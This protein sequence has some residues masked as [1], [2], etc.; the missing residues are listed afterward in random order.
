MANLPVARNFFVMSSNNPHLVYVILGTPGAGRRAVL[1]DLIQDG[2]A[3]D[4]KAL[5]LL[6]T[7]EEPNENDHRLGTV[8][9]WTW[10]DNLIALAPSAEP[11]GEPRTLASLVPGFTHVLFVTEGRRNP[12]DQLEV[13]KPWFDA[14]NLELARVITVVDCLLASQHPALRIWFDACIH[15]S[16]VVLLANRTGVPNKWMSDFRRRYEDAFIP[17]LFEFVKDGK[18]ANP[19]LILEPQ[20]RRVSHVFDDDVDWIINDDIEDEDEIEEGE[21]EV[22]VEPETDKYFERRQNG[23]RVIELPDLADVIRKE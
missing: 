23:K 4:E 8:V 15:F 2:L 1:A 13:L 9:R 6:A 17:A 22:T 14:A 11:A 12:V 3:P 18:V 16:D 7:S 5:T 20:A 21:E 19:A 10:Q